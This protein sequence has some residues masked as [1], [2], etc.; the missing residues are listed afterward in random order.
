MRY[1][2]GGVLPGKVDYEPEIGE[3]IMP[4]K[5]LKEIAER[6][7]EYAESA[8]S[9]TTTD[10]ISRQQAI[11]AWDKLSKRGRTEFDQ[12][13]MTLPPVTPTE[14][15]GEWKHDGSD[16]E[17]RWVCSEPAK[18]KT[19]A[20][21]VEEVSEEICDH[22]CKWPEQYGDDESGLL[23]EKCDGCPLNRL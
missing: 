5:E 11:G 16:W 23:N 15:T 18:P 9:A 12:V 14:R 2:K 1:A 22:Y 10:C 20:Q 17:N 19:I 8:E 7:M 3:R 13:L 4:L 21:I 6:L